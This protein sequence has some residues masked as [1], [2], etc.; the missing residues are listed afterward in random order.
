MYIDLVVVG[1]TASGK[2]LWASHWAR[3]NGAEIVSADSRQIYR[4]MDIGTSKPDPSLMEEIPHH[5]I[6]IKSPEESYSAGQF[7]RD[8]KNAIQGILERGNKVIVVGGTGFYVKALLFGLIE[9]P[10]ED[11]SAREAFLKGKEFCSTDLLY[12]LLLHSDPERAKMLSA[13]D[14]Y[15]VL[16]ALWLNEWLGMPASHLY[17]AQ[18]MNTGISYGKLIGLDPGRQSLYGRIDQRAEQMLKNGWDNEVRRLL[19]EG[20]S[21]ESYGFRS[22]GYKEV[23]QYVR[24][25]IEKTAALK[26]IQQKTRQFA[27]RQMTW[28]RHMAPIDWVP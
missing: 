6:D 1:P 13:G 8:A 10:R 9:L 23:L 17:E 3:E 21:P 19:S 7:V 4:G 16:R 20:F 18:K 15:R 27:K 5:L 28:F 24:G 12:E 26:A 25:E 14:R 22:L 2:T 11:L